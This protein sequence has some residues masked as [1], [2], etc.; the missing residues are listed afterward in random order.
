[1]SDAHTRV[2]AIDLGEKRIGL[3]LSDPLRVTAQPLPVEPA[4][5]PRK[6]VSRI[7]ELVAENEVDT[8]VVGLPLLLSGEDGENATHARAFRDRLAARLPGIRVELWDERLTSAEAERVMVAAD[9]R[10]KRRKQKIDALAAVLILQ[11]FLDAGAP[12]SGAS[13]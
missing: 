8:V 10:R 11:S 2:L 13:A 6:D 9:V 4:V 1:M 5:G 12:S 3:A 7:C